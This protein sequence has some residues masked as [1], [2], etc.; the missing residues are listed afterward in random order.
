MEYDKMPESLVYWAAL[1]SREKARL[2][3]EAAPPYKCSKE[4]QTLQATD[5]RMCDATN[6]YFKTHNIEGRLRQ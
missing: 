1:D 5:K 2:E 3:Y 4:F 6:A